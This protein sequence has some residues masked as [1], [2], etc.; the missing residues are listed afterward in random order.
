MFEWEQIGEKLWHYQ[1]P[2]G[3][4]ISIFDNSTSYEVHLCSTDINVSDILL[5]IYNKP[6]SLDD[7]K[8]LSRYLTI[9]QFTVLQTQLQ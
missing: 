2:L 9:H 8:E 1:M 3:L 5:A 4:Y 7:I 6:Y